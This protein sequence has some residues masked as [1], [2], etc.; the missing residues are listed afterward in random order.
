MRTHILQDRHATRTKALAAAVAA[1]AI[2][3]VGL[4]QL[5]TPVLATALPS[6]SGPASAPAG[7][8][9]SFADLV[10]RVQPAVVSIATSGAAVTAPTLPQERFRFPPGSSLDEFMQ[11][12]F[13][14]APMDQPWA[15]P[16]TN[17]VGSGFIIDAAG[18]VVTNRHVIDGAEQITVI[19]SDGTELEATLKGADTKTDLALLEVEADRPLPYVEF[20]DSDSARVGD[21]VVAIGNPFGLG[22]TTTTGIISARGRDLNA[23]PLDDFIQ[24]DAPLNRG[25]SGGPLFD[26][27]GRVIGV[28]TAI[29]SPNGGNV[30]IGFAIP[31]SLAQSVVT[32]LRENGFV[33]RGWLG[34]QIQAVSA[35]I[36][37]SLGLPEATGALVVEVV[38]GGPADRAGLKAGDV[39]RR[40]DGEPVE[41]MRELPRLVSATQPDTVVE[42]EVHRDGADQ[43][44]AVTIEQ[45]ED[46]Q[47][48]LAGARTGSGEHAGELGLR[49]AEL[50]PDARA[51]YGIDND[52]QGVLI[53]GVRAGSPAAQQGLRPGDL[54]RQVNRT[55]VSEP[56]DVVAEVKQTRSGDRKVVLM[57]IERG[58]QSRFVALR[59]A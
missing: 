28:N 22:G 27:Q 8:P 56:G 35:D 59:I 40:Y 46:E 20:G 34:V 38:P 6:E 44:L 42:I 57:Q 53:A 23:G 41:R 45:T 19:L 7:Q 14:Q 58:G 26:T 11:R 30:G 36:A 55:V 33:D 13:E 29:F 1:V 24:I 25:N 2:T 9:G 47:R 52:R 43:T 10:E 15:M 31:A 21:W 32:S 48:V 39:I 51:R 17:A 3:A 37:E 12:F 50:D 5:A 16:K 4:S 54:I 49:L 18:H